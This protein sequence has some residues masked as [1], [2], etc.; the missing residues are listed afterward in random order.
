MYYLT[1]INV[2]IQ[3]RCYQLN[4]QDTVRGIRI[5]TE[6]K[7]RKNVLQVGLWNH[8]PL[9]LQAKTPY[10]TMSLI[11][12]LSTCTFIVNHSSPGNSEYNVM[13]SRP[14]PSFIPLSTSLEKI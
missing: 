6:M 3:H 13:L 7:E 2:V 4:D 12:Q 8:G 14:V 9:F 5:L 11:Y 1:H 10:C